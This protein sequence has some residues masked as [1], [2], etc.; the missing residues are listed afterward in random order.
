MRTVFEFPIGPFVPISIVLLYKPHQLIRI[1]LGI[2]VSTCIWTLQAQKDKSTR[3][4]I[5]PLS[6]PR[7]LTAKQVSHCVKY[8]ICVCLHVIW[9]HVGGLRVCGCAS[10]F[11]T[12]L[13]SLD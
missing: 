13:T 2:H 7:S 11:C 3:S 4:H 8:M 9:V 5:H 12:H 6:S 10:A 1:H